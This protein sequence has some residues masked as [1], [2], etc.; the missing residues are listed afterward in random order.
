MTGLY[1]TTAGPW[2]VDGR[3]IGPSGVIGVAMTCHFDSFGGVHDAP[4]YKANGKAITQV[5]AMLALVDA[6]AD[7]VNIEDVRD[8]ARAIVRELET[9]K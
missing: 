6:V 3:V 2:V 1:G 8:M 4:N 9:R 7:W 5:P